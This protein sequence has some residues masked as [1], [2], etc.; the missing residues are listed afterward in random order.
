MRLLT[1]ILAIILSACNN[2]TYEVDK[3]TT[4][5]LIW[6]KPFIKS[7]SIIYISDKGEK[8]TIIFKA[9]EAASDS[10]RSFEQGFSNTN[11]LTVVYE[12][13]KGSYHQSAMMSDGKTR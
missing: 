11:Y 3:F 13:S 12:F 2:R 8:D 1:L 6:Y 5:E 10:T 9:P 7:D 4:E